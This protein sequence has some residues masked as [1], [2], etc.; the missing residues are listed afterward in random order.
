MSTALP[1]LIGSVIGVAGV[2][3]LSAFCASALPRS[4]RTQ[5]GSCERRDLHLDR[6]CAL[7]VLGIVQSCGEVLGPESQACP[8][9]F[10][11]SSRSAPGFLRGRRV[12]GSD[13]KACSL[14]WQ[15][16]LS[17]AAPRQSAELCTRRDLHRDRDLHSRRANHS[18][19]PVAR[20]GWS[21]SSLSA[22]DWL[23][24]NGRILTS[25]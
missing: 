3:V 18:F 9:G 24:D 21:R 22:R 19:F 10:L 13:R 12:L 4:P 23:T 2:I 20:Q 16:G 14:G 7:I 15:Q 17:C 8:A 1:F 11:R 25:P 5:A 6:S